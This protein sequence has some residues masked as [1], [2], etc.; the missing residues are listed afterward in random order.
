M[1]DTTTAE[2]ARFPERRDDEWCADYAIRCL[3]GIE[4]LHVGPDGEPLAHDEAVLTIGAWCDWLAAQGWRVARCFA[5]HEAETLRGW[6]RSQQA[7]AVPG[8][9]IAFV[10][11]HAVPLIDGEWPDDT[12]GGKRVLAAAA[13]AA[14]R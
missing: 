3:T 12:H 4:L 9:L 10:D 7:R 6:A 1:P 11:G 5:A 2:A 13:P 14:A 8:S